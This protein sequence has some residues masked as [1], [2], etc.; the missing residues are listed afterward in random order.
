MRAVD[1]LDRI[2]SSRYDVDAIVDA[3]NR[4]TTLSDREQ[5]ETFSLWEY[6]GLAEAAHPLSSLLRESH[7]ETVVVRGLDGQLE[8]L[9]VEPRTDEWHSGPLCRENLIGNEELAESEGAL[10]LGVTD[11][12]LQRLLAALPTAPGPVISF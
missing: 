4:Y 12:G 1:L 10:E 9:W 8:M 3:A 11:E 5:E 2:E 7:N 6:S